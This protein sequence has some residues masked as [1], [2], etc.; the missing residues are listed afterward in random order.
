MNVN[1]NANELQSA[2]T[3][4][5]Q[6]DANSTS[7]KMKSK[8]DPKVHKQFDANSTSPQNE[9]KRVSLIE[10]PFSSTNGPDP[11]FMENEIFNLMKW[12]IFS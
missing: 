1:A 8:W 10:I 5:Q 2:Q 12:D 11:P 6:F 4:R 9:E 3:I 7:P